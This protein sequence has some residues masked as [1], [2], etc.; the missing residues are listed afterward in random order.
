M[1]ETAAD[2]QPPIERPV[3]RPPRRRA[4]LKAGG[5]LAAAWLAGCTGG[6]ADDAK[7][8]AAAADPAPATTRPATPPATATPTR[9]RPDWKALASALDGDLVRPGD[10]GYETD[11]RLYNARY[12]GLR[13]AGIAYVTGA[14]DIRACLD[15]ATRTG[16]VPVVRSGGHSYAGWS[17]GDGRLIID[18]SR[19]DAVRLDGTTATIGAGARLIDVYSTL[20]DQGRCVPGGSCPS[21]GISGLTLGGGHGVLSRSMGLTCDNLTGATLITPDGRTHEVSADAEPDVFWALRGAGNGQ[22][23][24][25]TSLRFATHPTPDVVTGYLTWPWSRA[26]AVVRSWQRWGPDQPDHIWSAL[27]LDCAPGGTPAVSVAMLSTGSRDDLAAAADRLADAPGGPGPA[28]TVSLRPHEFLDAMFSYAGCSGLSAAQCHLSPTG[29][30]GRET[31]TARSDFYDTELPDSGVDTL[32]TQAQRL[33]NQSGGGAGSIALTA[34]GGAV[35]RPAPTATAFPHRTSRVLVQYLASDALST[36]S[37]L[38]TTHA[39]LRRYASGA[40]YQN[41]TDPTLPTWRTAYY[42]PNAPRLTALK[43]R[44]DP[45][46]LFTFPQAL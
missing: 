33:A 16:T 38:D 41:Y 14:D 42:G 36:T 28:A 6:G 22:F 39:A 11:H 32:L 8:S 26:A 34:L 10:S 12:D 23:G 20:G 1:N 5:A 13:P 25:V 30:L 40:A 31:Y 35:N 29:H 44:L 9:V 43:S 37:W 7:N 19:L 46:R 27:H 4:A 15:F 3:R 21:V 2:Q 18:V 17:S 24:V 45:N